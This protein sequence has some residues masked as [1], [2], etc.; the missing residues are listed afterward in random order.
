M[1]EYTS[2]KT[3]FQDFLKCLMLCRSSTTFLAQNV[4]QKSFQINKITFNFF[5]C[6]RLYYVIY[7][8]SYAMRDTVNQLPQVFLMGGL[9]G[10]EVL[11]SNALIYFTEYFLEHV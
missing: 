5:S 3:S 9:H 1:N 6:K 10:N 7:N 4:A 8:N 2:L 11:G